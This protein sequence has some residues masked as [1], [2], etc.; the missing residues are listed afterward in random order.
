MSEAFQRFLESN[1]LEQYLVVGVVLFALLMV[2]VVIGLARSVIEFATV[3][4][5]SMEK[6]S[7]APGLTL[8]NFTGEYDNK[9]QPWLAQLLGNTLIFTFGGAIGCILGWGI[10]PFIILQRTITASRKKRFG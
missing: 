8:Q 10:I 6:I 7:V 5:P 9:M 3:E 1:I 2:S 4:E